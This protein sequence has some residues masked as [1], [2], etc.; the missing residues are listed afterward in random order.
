MYDYA[1][2]FK[3]RLPD[4]FPKEIEGCQSYPAGGENRLG[5]G[6][7][8]GGQYPGGPMI[9]VPKNSFWPMGLEK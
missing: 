2:E 5:Q 9:K 6:W 1:V 4:N 8:C 3:S 7:V